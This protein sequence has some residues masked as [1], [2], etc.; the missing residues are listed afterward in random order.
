MV[1]YLIEFKHIAWVIRIAALFHEVVQIAN[2][3]NLFIQHFSCYRT[4]TCNDFTMSIIGLIRG[5]NTIFGFRIKSCVFERD[6][7]RSS[8]I[9]TGTPGLRS[10]DRGSV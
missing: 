9:H 4:L 2:I 3:P 6:I 1:V 10:F 5:E 7:L 8:R